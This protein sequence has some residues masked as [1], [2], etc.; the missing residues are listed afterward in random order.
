ML[1]LARG[2]AVAEIGVREGDWLAGRTLFHLALPEEGVL[3]LGVQRSSGAFVGAPRANDTI[4][5]GDTVILYGKREVLA[6]LDEREGD[7]SGVVTRARAVQAHG[8][9][10]EQEAREEHKRAR[11]ER[12]DD[13]AEG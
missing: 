13:R 6:D 8:V 3:V 11:R 4:H 9:Y 5:A 7:L 10:E 12:A 2:Y 1:H